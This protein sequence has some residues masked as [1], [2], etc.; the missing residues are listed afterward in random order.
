MDTTEIQRFIREHYE[1]LDKN[2]L[3]NIE[4]MDKLLESYNLAKL[5]HEK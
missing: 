4:E 3:N 1:Q 2:K 5:N